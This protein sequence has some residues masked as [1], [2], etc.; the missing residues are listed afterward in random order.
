[1][2]LEKARLEVERQR[3]AIAF[4]QQR[5]QKALAYDEDIHRQKLA[6]LANPHG[7][8]PQGGGRRSPLDQADEGEFPP[9]AVEISPRYPGVPQKEI[10]AIF[11]GKF[12][13]KNLYKL[14]RKASLD[15]EDEDVISL[16]DG[17]LRTKKRTGTTKDY[18]NPSTW[19]KAFI[20][21]VSIL[22][23]FEKYRD[24]TPPLL[25]FYA[26]IMELS[27]TYVWDRVLLL[28]LT[29]HNERLLSDIHDRKAWKIP[30]DVVDEH[31]RGALKPAKSTSPILL[32]V[33]PNMQP[34]VAS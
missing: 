14:H 10:A 11:E 26:R 13:P 16:S 19:S 2:G 17:K 32:E 4:E 9:E 15:I 3:M 33:Q 7:S 30:S 21:Y 31:L 8:N 5:Q 34:T 1:L 6:Q 27:Q 20:Q 28:A 23:E 24:L 12:N 25:G 18:P 29:F 22:S